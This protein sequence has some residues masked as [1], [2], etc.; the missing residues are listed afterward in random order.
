MEFGH[1]AIGGVCEE[2]ILSDKDAGSLST[3]IEANYRG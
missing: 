3:Y 2:C 1:G